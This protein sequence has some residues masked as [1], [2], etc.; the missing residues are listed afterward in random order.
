MTDK[1]I[2]YEVFNRITGKTKRYKTSA[3][4]SRA[5][6]RADNAYGAY[7]TTRKAIYA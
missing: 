4:A 6:D 3:S 7:I 5:M 2:A 1:P